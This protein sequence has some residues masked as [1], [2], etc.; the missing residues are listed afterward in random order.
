MTADA[1]SVEDQKKSPAPLTGKS[2]PAP[3]LGPVL[4][5]DAGAD[6]TDESLLDGYLPL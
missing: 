5:V 2:D 6:D 4:E 3:E 1:T